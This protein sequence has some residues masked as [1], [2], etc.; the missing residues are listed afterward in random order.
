MLTTSSLLFALIF[1]IYHSSNRH[2]SY[3]LS[4]ELAATTVSQSARSKLEFLEK[5][6]ESARYARPA[7]NSENLY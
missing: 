5:E 4:E 2:G 7:A 1:I 3:S 6:F